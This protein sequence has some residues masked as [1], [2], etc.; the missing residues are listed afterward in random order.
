MKITTVREIIQK[1]GSKT[2][3]TIEDNINGSDMNQL[4]RNLDLI[5]FYDSQSVFRKVLRFIRGKNSV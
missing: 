5:G 1:D 2:T 3:I 4:E